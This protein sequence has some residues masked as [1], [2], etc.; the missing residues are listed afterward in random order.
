M[1]TVDRQMS[2][3]NRKYNKHASLRPHSHGSTHMS[4]GATRA[5]CVEN[6]ES[7]DDTRKTFYP[8]A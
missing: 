8:L 7:V 5:V 3:N 1:L 4:S 2:S 6:F